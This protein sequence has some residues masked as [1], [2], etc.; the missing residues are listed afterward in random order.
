MSSLLSHGRIHDILAAGVPEGGWRKSPSRPIPLPS[1]S[2][3]SSQLVRGR[4]K[5]RSGCPLHKWLPLW[6]WPHSGP[7]GRQAR[8][9]GILEGQEVDKAVTVTVPRN[10]AATRC[11][12][13]MRKKALGPRQA[14]GLQGHREQGS[15]P[16]ECLE[17]RFPGSPCPPSLTFDGLLDA[18]G[19]CRGCGC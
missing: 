2:S 18:E 7:A 5:K 17:E 8:Q 1:S 3:W 15:S 9:K 6:K 13:V 10:R 19:C 16:A 4:L 14:V 12:R 11:G